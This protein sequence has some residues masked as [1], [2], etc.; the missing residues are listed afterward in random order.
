MFHIEREAGSKKRW[1]CNL[2]E[3]C[4]GHFLVRRT[5]SN[6][7]AWFN[8]ASSRGWF[9]SNDNTSQ[10]IIHL[11]TFTP[12][13]W[14]LLLLY[15][16]SKE[17]ESGD[18][19]SS[20]VQSVSSRLS[21]LS[22]DTSRSELFEMNNMIS[23]QYYTPLESNKRNFR[24][25]LPTLFLVNIQP[26]SNIRRSHNYPRSEDGLSPSHSSDY[27]DQEEFSNC[28]QQQV[29]T[30]HVVLMFILPKCGC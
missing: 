26:L 21:T 3:E 25:V 1:R 13:E 14:T 18:Y 23:P 4:G 2:S 22:M 19:A 20:D 17:R 6:T 9:P 15:R 30:V 27:E 10:V 29:A 8:F 24:F 12:R 5:P 7:S 28:S 16:S 11:S